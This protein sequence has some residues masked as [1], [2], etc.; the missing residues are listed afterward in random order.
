MAKK[1]FHFPR[2]SIKRGNIKVDVKLDR[3]E[4]NF[5]E[6]QLWLDREIMT[7]MVPFMPKRDGHLINLTKKIFELA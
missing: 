5:Q 1:T 2:F 7:N 6:A 4:K 3:F